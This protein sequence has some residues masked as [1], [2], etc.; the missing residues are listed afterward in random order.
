LRG[1]SGGYPGR[2]ARVLWSGGLVLVWV[3]SLTVLTWQE[4]TVAVVV[5]VPGAV[6]A[7]SARKAFAGRWR[8][9][10]GWLRPLRVLPGAVVAETFAVWRA[11]VRRL[12]GGER[13]LRLGQE[14][15]EARQA[16]AVALLA[17]SPGTVVVDVDRKANVARIHSFADTEGA[18]ERAVGR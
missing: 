6:V 5:A 18:M 15:S 2:V 4:F 8:I 17:A 13:E 12:R 7:T 16:V 14:R 1:S 3:A 11:A 10:I 9:R